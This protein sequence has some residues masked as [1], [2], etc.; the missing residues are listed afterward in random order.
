MGTIIRGAE[1]STFKTTA[2]SLGKAKN[3]DRNGN[4]NRYM[5]VTVM[6]VESPADRSKVFFFEEE[7]DTELGV[8]LLDILKNFA[9]PDPNRPGSLLVNLKEAKESNEF[10]VDGHSVIEPYLRWEGG[11]FETYKLRKGLCYANDVDGKPTLDRDGNP[12]VRDRIKVFTQ[13]KMIKPNEDGN[14]ETVYFKKF[15]LH[16]Q[17]AKLESRF[18]KKA[19]NATVNTQEA[20]SAEQNNGTDNNAAATTNNPD[21]IDF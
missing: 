20:S 19:V 5:V 3:A 17:G 18:F 2:I 7:L 10:S 15:D 8:N 12:V 6:D 11:M 16:T 14:M 4:K 9:K 21:D 1:L 13:V